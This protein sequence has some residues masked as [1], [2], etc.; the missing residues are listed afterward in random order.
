MAESKASMENGVKQGHVELSEETM[1]KCVFCIYKK[2]QYTCDLTVD[3]A[4]KV[5]ALKCSLSS[6]VCR[7]ISMTYRSDYLD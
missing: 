3:C 1:N 7:S 2:I 5:A 6:A 4:V